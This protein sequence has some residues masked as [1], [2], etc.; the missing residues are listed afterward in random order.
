[1]LALAAHLL[2]TC[3]ALAAHLL[4]TCLALAAHLLVDPGIGLPLT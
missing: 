4:R 1:M 3:L 2:R